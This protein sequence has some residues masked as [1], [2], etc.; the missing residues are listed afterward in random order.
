[1]S[2]LLLGRIEPLVREALRTGLSAEVAVHE[3]NSSGI[4]LLLEGID[5]GASALVTSRQDAETVREH[6]PPSML[7]IGISTDVQ[8]VSVSLG[9]EGH[10]LKNPRVAAIDEL[11]H[12]HAV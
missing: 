3:S 1:M 6:A 10:F 11:I 8:D 4:Q 9:A 2:V 12:E 7:V 5:R